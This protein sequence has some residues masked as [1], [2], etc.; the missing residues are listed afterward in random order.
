MTRPRRFIAYECRAR[1]LL[2]SPEKLLR[3]LRKAGAR[4]DRTAGVSG[5]FG[6]LRA[7][8]ADLID[9]LRAWVAGDYT[10]VSVHFVVTILAAVLY[11]VAPLDLVFDYIPGVGLLDDATVIAFALGSTRET[12]DVF[13]QW[14]REHPGAAGGGGVDE[15]RRAA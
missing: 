15:R 1:A 9:L 5:R 4:L 7:D 10:G 6:V 3:L 8:L 11:F 2:R 13:R 12:L 14:R